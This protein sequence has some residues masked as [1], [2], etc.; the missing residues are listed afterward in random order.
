MI[1][2]PSTRFQRKY[3]DLPERL[4]KEFDKKMILFQQNRQHPSL[5]I[6]KMGG[7]YNIYEGSLTMK[8]RFTFENIDGGIALR[9]I[10]E[11][12]KVL[13]NP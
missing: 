12:D 10:G 8:Y 1:I 11:H 6:K 4:Q 9:N 3:D 5:R 2:R 13:N 7:Y